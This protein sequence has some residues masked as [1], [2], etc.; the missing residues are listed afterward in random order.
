MSSTGLVLIGCRDVRDLREVLGR[1]P[2]EL[3]GATVVAVV[4]DAPLAHEL[5]AADGAVEVVRNAGPLGSGARQKA[6]YRRALELG[7]DPIALVRGDGH[8]ALEPLPALLR[9][10]ERGDADVVVGSRLLD[11]GRARGEG[12]AVRRVVGLRLLSW[13]Q[14]RLSGVDVS[15]LHS[16]CRVLRAAALRRVS[17]EAF[18]DG[19]PFDTELILALAERDLRIA[20][21][22][23]PAGSGGL[24]LRRVAPYA[25][26]CLRLSARAWLANRRGVLAFPGPANL[27]EGAPSVTLAR[28]AEPEPARKPKPLPIVD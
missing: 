28:A 2:P 19:R 10:L 11:S 26:R 27:S 4:D 20:E 15:E 16:G 7:L 14:R 17:Y 25:A 24:T 13:A 18:S 23:I 12:M 21:L 5:G 22:P 8:H 9:L 3:R 6:G 1:R